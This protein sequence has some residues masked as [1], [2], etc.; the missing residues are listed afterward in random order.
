MLVGKIIKKGEHL[1]LSFFIVMNLA[2][3]EMANPTCKP[4]ASLELD[5]F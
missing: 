3:S 1:L 5:I 4:I 2:Q